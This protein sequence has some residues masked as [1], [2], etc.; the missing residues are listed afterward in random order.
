MSAPSVVQEILEESDIKGT[1]CD[2]PNDFSDVMNPLDDESLLEVLFARSFEEDP[3]DD[4]P[5]KE[6]RQSLLSSSL[7]VTDDDVQARYD[8]LRETVASG[9]LSAALKLMTDR[10]RWVSQTRNTCKVSSCTHL[11]LSESEFCVEHIVNDEKQKLFC[12]CP[13]CKRPHP[14]GCHCLFCGC[15]SSDDKQLFD[16]F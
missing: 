10:H 11:A 9:N 7:S 4:E 8:L 16:V 15:E 5:A 14:I 1:L 2:V 3:A 12:E 6:T 13:T